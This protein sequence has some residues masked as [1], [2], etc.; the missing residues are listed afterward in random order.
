MT[1]TVFKQI[2]DQ[3]RSKK[4]QYKEF[5]DQVTIKN[6]RGINDLTVQLAFPVTVLA[7]PNASGKTTVLFACACAY[8]PSGR[9]ARQYAPTALFPN[10]KL[11][12]LPNISDF[13]ANTSLEF[14]YTHQGKRMAMKWGK[15]KSWNKSYMGQKGGQ[16]PKRTIYLRTLANLTSPS[17]V[18]S[19]LQ[20]ANGKYTTA[21]VTADLLAFAQQIL[22]INYGDVTLIAKGTKDLLF[23]RR[24]DANVSY[25]E[26]HMSAGERA[27]LRVSKD[28][29]NLRDA[30][31]LI[32]EI[33]AGLHPIT[34]QFFMLQLQRLAL[35]NNLQI[36]VTSHSPVVLDAVPIEARVFL[37]RTDDNVVV[38]PAYRDIIQ[39]AFYGQSLE[40]LSIL[41]EDDIAEGFLN[42]LL[43]HLNPKIG[44]AHDDVVIGRD[45]GK[46]QF[47]MHIEAIG[48]FNQLGQFLFVLDGDALPMEANLKAT[49]SRFGVAIQPLFLPGTDIP[50]RWAWETLHTYQTECANLLGLP[51]SELN[52]HLKQVDHLYTNAADK[53]TNIIKNKFYTFSQN[54]RRDGPVLM[55]Q[56]ARH[57]AEVQ[58]PSLMPFVNELEQQIRNWQSR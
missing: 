1:Q 9:N 12:G 58:R 18:R 17:E 55:R 26:F 24:T 42:G 45:T 20:I 28:I 37:E 41:C 48:K 32:D 44:L 40:K 46:E 33:E 47:P 31:V 56:L 4:S 10:L 21:P 27:V 23:A 35:R 3:L 6:L 14:Y 57:E 53:P 30:I 25:S 29:S 50:E 11:K 13:E 38:K 43:D 34:Q 49:A 7:G 8:H 22:P 52:R 2:W 5:L 36:I 16:Q 19:V 54:I 15:G 39:K 51:E